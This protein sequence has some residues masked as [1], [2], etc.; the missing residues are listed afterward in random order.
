[1]LDVLRMLDEGDSWCSE[2]PL[3]RKRTDMYHIRPYNIIFDF[4]IVLP[5]LALVPDLTYKTVISHLPNEILEMIFRFLDPYTVRTVARLVSRLWNDIALSPIFWED[6]QL[7]RSLRMETDKYLEVLCL[8]RFSRLKSIVFGWNTKVDDAVLDRLIESNPRIYSSVESLEIHRCH[9][10][11]DQSMK[12]IA[13]FSNLRCLR[14]YN[15]SNWRGITDSGLAEISKLVHIE[16]LQLNYFKRISNEGLVH[17]SKLYNIR[18]LHISGSSVI[19]DQGIQN[20]STLK[21]LTSLTLSLC[22]T[23]TDKSLRFIATTFPQVRYLSLGYNNPQ[24]FFS[25]EGLNELVKLKEL[26]ELRLERSWGLLGGHGVK[27]LK[28]LIPCLV[29]RHW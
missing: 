5:S 16:T 26:K 24:S 13:K 17:I 18:E 9:G 7:P 4:S 11:G 28:E 23:L 21:K 12:K 6:F 1:M 20:L 25:D 19:N 3:K 22:G 29:V 27:T 2:P 10:L 15:S 14:M 8:P